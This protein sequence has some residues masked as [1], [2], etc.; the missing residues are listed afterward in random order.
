MCLVFIVTLAVFPVL[1]VKINSSSSNPV[2]ARDYFQPV[3]TFL[4]FNL[5]DYFGRTCAEFILW[6]RR[7]SCFLFA[8]SILRIA[9]IPLFLLCNHNPNSYL[10]SVFKHDAWYTTF[11]SAFGFSN[12][13]AFALLMMMVPESEGEKVGCMMAAMIGLGLLIGSLLSFAFALI[14]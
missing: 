8:I 14:T 4:V 10:P 9:F 11:M 5:F 2:W 3:A 12:G 7:G 6:P 1:S 13:Y